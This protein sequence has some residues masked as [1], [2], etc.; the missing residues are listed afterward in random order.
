MGT[1]GVGLYSNDLAADLRDEFNAVVRAPW[2]GDKLLVWA[3]S[4]YPSA[5]DPSDDEYSDLRLVL[6]HLFWSYGIDHQPTFETARRII[7]D[8]I[9]LKAKRSLGMGERDLRKRATV[10]DA[11]A[12]KLAASNP[13]PRLRRILTKPEP[14][15]IEVGDCLV[16]PTSHGQ[17]R[18]PYV[19]PKNEDR[20]YA[21][22][23][24]EADGWGA[25][26]LLMRYHRYGVFARYVIA[27]L[28]SRPE[29]KPALS[30]FAKLSIRHSNRIGW[31]ASHIDRRVHAVE[32]SREHLKRMRVEILGSLAIDRRKVEAEFTPGEPPITVESNFANKARIDPPGKEGPW[33]DD[34]IA[35][36]LAY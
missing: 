27:V 34:P 19:G 25:A 31:S 21:I 8:G 4:N 20:F 18:N 13:K 15:V 32:T 1:W 24:W 16:Y 22:H 17:A 6:A 23:H 10:L 35:A 29:A 11:L 28:R 2:D 3:L 26:I 33:V 30:D 36:Y 14:F 12:N 9:D 5:A 7:A